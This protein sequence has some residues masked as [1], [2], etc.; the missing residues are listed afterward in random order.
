[1]H[2]V[3][4]PVV[5]RVRTRIGAL[6]EVMG[7]HGV[8]GVV[9]VAPAN[10]AY[11]TGFRA[12]LYSR[13]LV[14]VV[15]VDRSFL[16]VPGLEE[17]HA[18]DEAIVDEVHAYYE[19]PS[20]N[21]QTLS[22]LDLL[23]DLLSAEPGGRVGVEFASCP[24]G[25]TRHLSDAGYVPV[26]LGPTITAMRA[27]KDDFEMKAIADSAKLVATGVNG[28]IRACRA[29]AT[30]IEVDGAGTTAVL[31]ALADRAD[32]AT[33]DQLVMT[34][35]GTERSVLPHAF[36][37]TRPLEHGDVLIHTRQVGLNGYRAELERTV[38]IG[39]PGA[40]QRRL[41]DVMR[42][43]QDAARSTV[44]AGASCSSVDRA[45]REIFEREG[46]DSYAIHRSGHG[47][48]LSPHEPPY[49]RFDNDELLEEGM[50]I[51][52]EPGIYL[53]GVGGFR[54]SDTVAVTSTG[55][56]LLTSFATDVE[57]LTRG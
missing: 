9:C 11:L 15:R 17:G 14:L 39:A 41:F 44:R 47:I 24:T 8:V 1:M 56:E 27:V 34:P 57:T 3:R 20:G 26:D 48:G 51:T 35:S 55:S 37:T 6:K 13:P 40:E 49:L 54:H 16:I 18:R 52:I 46:L 53:P 45:A 42:A 33:I 29:G 25:L 36:S 23:D 21:S 19:H 5:E 30:E 32:V 12:L 4:S 50:V 38:F 2:D 10:Q 7:R 22:H 28:S 43:A 31:E